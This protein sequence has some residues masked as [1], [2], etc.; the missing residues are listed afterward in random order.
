MHARRLH[1]LARNPLHSQSI[2]CALNSVNQPSVSSISRCFT[3]SVVHFREAYLKCLVRHKN[4][5]TFNHLEQV[6]AW[7]RYFDHR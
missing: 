3:K 5:I 1:R 2:L 4:C 6:L 7:R